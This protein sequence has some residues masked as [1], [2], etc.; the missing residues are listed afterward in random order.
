MRELFLLALAGVSAAA[1]AQVIAEAVR[2]PAVVVTGT[3]ER[4]L[5]NETPASVGVIEGET[6]R[7]DRPTHPAQILGQVPGVAVAVTNGEGH[8]TAIRQPFTTSP[9]Y[10]FLEDGI[11]IRSTGFF[12]H[13]AL[14]EINIPAAG[15]IEVIRGPGTALYGSDAI[16]GIVNV[17]TRVPP[18]RP[19]ASASPE[20]G[21]F[22]WR[23]LLAGGGRSAERDAWR[24]DLNLTHTDG[25]RDATAYDRQ[26]GLA[27]WDRTF[28]SG[29]T[30]ATVL[31]FSRIDQETGANS[32]LIYGDYQDHPTLNYLPIAYRKVNALRL[33]TS[34][35]QAFGDSLLSITPYLRD[36]KMEL[37]ASFMLSFDPTVSTTENRSFGVMAKW[38]RDWPGMMR[39]RLIAGL[40]LDVSPGGRE[41][42]RLNVTP[43]GSGAARVFD[44]YTVG[45]RVYDYDVTFRAISP[46]VH[47]E[48]SP[49]DRLR[50][51]AGVRYDSLSYR[52][53]N[54]LEGAPIAVPGAFPGLRFYGQA[55][56]TTQDF[57]NTT[58]KLGATYEVAKEVNLY[59]SRNEG[60]RAPSEGQIFRPAAATSAA[61][62]AVLVRSSLELK[63]I[64]ATQTEVGA[65]G[66][67]GPFSYDLVAYRLVKRDDIVSFRDTATNFTQSVNAGRTQH[68]GVEAGVTAEL[69][70]RFEIAGA[71]SHARH[72]Y[73]NWVTAAG[74]FTG[75][76]IEAAPRVLANVRITWKPLPD[77]RVTLEWVKVGEYWL[78]AA[79]TA[80]YG[81]HALLNARANWPLTRTI[82]L[83][84][85]ATN[86]TDRRFADSASISSSTPVYS[87]GLPRAYTAGAEFRW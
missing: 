54:H 12:N 3:R 22:G 39:A 28:P 26:G 10:L 40:D 55:G 43:K 77:A 83:F 73:E 56:D 15:G 45:P 75:K 32:P 86:I 59:V 31:A 53:D 57:H 80:K 50:L 9:V 71:F 67:V 34:W 13:N 33:S 36:D 5:L 27:R 14:Y 37:L 69:P 20:I 60:F 18:S 61:A 78:D 47:A 84:A 35:E 42:D 87:P 74:D 85:S 63:P 48:L 58:P 66:S 65:R 76:E 30:L 17:L 25:W 6:V 49:L 21:S 4:E 52:F 72:T 19:E 79:N 51:T 70:A 64:K 23:R 16:G 11:P 2:Q 38:R 44:S 24:A 41:E 62:A 81:G 82:G 46:Y 8:A 68:E 7:Q 29:A 1:Q